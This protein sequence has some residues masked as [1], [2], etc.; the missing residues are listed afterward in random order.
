ML[1]SFEVENYRSI[2]YPVVLQMTAVNYYKESSEQLIDAELPGLSGLRFLR[3]AAIFGPNASGKTAIWRAL[4]TMKDIVLN[5]ASYMASTAFNHAPFRLDPEMLDEPTRFTVVFTSGMDSIRYEY[6][7][8][9]TENAIIEEELCAYPKGHRQT[10]F[11]RAMEDGATNI[12]G[13]GYLKVP[14]AV[15]P[16]LN[17]NMLLLSLLANFPNAESYK[18]VAPVV[19]WFINGLDMYSRAPESLNDFPFSGE[20]VSGERGTEGMR[21]FIQ[22]M[23]RQAD[24]GIYRA[25]VE[26][27]P[28]PEE[29]R[30]IL[31]HISPVQGG[32]DDV[33]KTV[34]FQHENAGKKMKLE[35]EDES[36]GTKQ[37][38]G[39]SGHIA[40][41]LE[42]GSTLFVDEVDASLHPVLVTE[43]I[44][45]FLHPESN[46]NGAQLIFTAHNPCLLENGLLRRDQIWFTEKDKEGATALYPLSDFSPRK[47]ETVIAGYLNGRYSAI[48]VIPECF[49]RCDGFDME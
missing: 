33:V 13:S 25:E 1:I 16:F 42:S 11:R 15:K 44:R 32:I 10:W 48:P 27:R 6:S 38:F 14:A 39:L 28:M 45:T 26:R 24:V 2:K 5:S 9:Y 17:D 3:S 34:V 31:E 8:A 18:R 41:A 20:I 4:A 40:Q 19:D 43:V 12:K 7:F 36:D 49:G 47:E 30:A 21:R 23:M 35:M 37:L 22:N 46:P 29:M